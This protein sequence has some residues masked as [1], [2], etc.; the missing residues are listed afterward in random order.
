[1]PSGIILTGGGAMLD[2]I[3]K[4]ASKYLSSAIRVAHPSNLLGLTDEISTPAY[5]TVCGLI[6][7]YLNKNNVDRGSKKN[8]NVSSLAS[9]GNGILNWIKTLMP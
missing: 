3:G 1:M 6:N 9:K 4:Y 5:S 8:V 7:Y 2:G